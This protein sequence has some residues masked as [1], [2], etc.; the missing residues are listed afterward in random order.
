MRRIACAALAAALV[1]P[2][3]AHGGGNW[4]PVP[5]AAVTQVDL[6]ALRVQGSMVTT[7]VRHAGAL[8]GWG[9]LNVEPPGKQPAA[10]R[11]VLLVAFDCHRRTARTLATQAFD[12]RGAPLFMS[13][14]P[15]AT[16]P[17]PANDD[18][19]WTYDALC[20]IARSRADSR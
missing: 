19:G 4:M 10:Q 2:M 3:L 13:S 5:G 6:G 7:W 14:V 9:S 15:G 17:L 18:L 1:T 8:G 16:V 20:E 11:S 12:A